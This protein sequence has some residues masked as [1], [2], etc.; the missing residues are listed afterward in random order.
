MEAIEENI[1]RRET[2]LLG[3]RTFGTEYL[4][5]LDAWKRKLD[6]YRRGNPDEVDFVEI[7][8]LRSMV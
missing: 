2:M 8:V 4:A 5:E 6:A 3:D 7:F 1:A